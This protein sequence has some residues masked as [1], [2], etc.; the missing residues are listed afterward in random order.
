MWSNPIGDSEQCPTSLVSHLACE[1]SAI[2]Y[3][4]VLK[5]TLE[6]D[7]KIYFLTF[8]LLAS[9][10][11]DA[12][13][14]MIAAGERISEMERVSSALFSDVIDEGTTVSASRVA[15]QED[16]TKDST[17][18]EQLRVGLFDSGEDVVDTECSQRRNPTDPTDTFYTDMLDRCQRGLATFLSAKSE[19]DLAI[20]Q[21][22]IVVAESV[23]DSR[24]KI[25]LVGQTLGRKV[26]KAHRENPHGFLMQCITPDR[27]RQNISKQSIALRYAVAQCGNDTTKLLPFFQKT[28]ISQCLKEYRLLRRAEKKPTKPGVAR[29]VIEGAPDTLNGR[30]IVELEISGGKALYIGLVDPR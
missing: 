4:L 14:V 8:M 16:V 30:I 6:Y 25:D 3:L 21:Y 18:V 1:L 20:W 29:L 27:S 7:K 9:F 15:E 17:K 23:I 28:G 10:N 5:F 13:V 11:D 22:L 12:A 2:K 24:F 26:T 19:S